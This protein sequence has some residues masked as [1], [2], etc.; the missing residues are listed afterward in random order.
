MTIGHQ[1][2]RDLL[3]TSPDADALEFS[4][5]HPLTHFFGFEMV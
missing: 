5:A 4:R 2:V 3:F 1:I